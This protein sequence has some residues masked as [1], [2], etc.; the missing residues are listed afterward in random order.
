MSPKTLSTPSPAVSTAGVTTAPG[1]HTAGWRISGKGAASTKAASRHLQGP[2]HAAPP[3]RSRRT[4]SSPR[5]PPCRELT[6]SVPFCSSVDPSPPTRRAWHT[7][8]LRSQP[9]DTQQARPAGPNCALCSCSRARGSSS[10]PMPPQPRASRM[11]NMTSQPEL[12]PAALYRL[13]RPLR[14]TA[15]VPSVRD[16]THTSLLEGKNCSPHCFKIPSPGEQC[17]VQT[18]GPRGS[19]PAT[20]TSDCEYYRVVTFLN[21]H[22]SVYSRLANQSHTSL[23][24]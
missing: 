15:P 12:N 8:P 7:T 4:D 6:P 22:G 23:I 9:P 3:E 16:H 24:L 11:P 13:R 14:K 10:F 20:T 19:E 2:H 1:A 5:G 17:S 21:C 18:T